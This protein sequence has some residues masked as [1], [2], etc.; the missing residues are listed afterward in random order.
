MVYVMPKKFDPIVDGV[1]FLLKKVVAVLLNNGGGPWRSAQIMS[2]VF[3][4]PV[5]YWRSLA[6]Q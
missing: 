2:A 6:V 3:G 5:R 1:K 4:C